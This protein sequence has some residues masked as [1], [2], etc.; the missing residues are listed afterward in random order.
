MDLGTPLLFSASC[1]LFLLALW[2]GWP[3]VV[4]FRLR[5]L[6]GPRLYRMTWHP[7]I[8]D[9]AMR[10]NN[11][12]SVELFKRM[13]FKEA[14]KAMFEYNAVALL[15]VDGWVF[16]NK[17]ILNPVAQYCAGEVALQEQAEQIT[18]GVFFLRMT[19]M[20]MRLEAE[21]KINLTN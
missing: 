3:I 11:P 4:F 8:T 19:L 12:D 1:T 2:Y 6:F 5:S 20:T 10:I 18:P 13:R 9:E 15:Q 16:S 14:H 21:G 7:I 17:T